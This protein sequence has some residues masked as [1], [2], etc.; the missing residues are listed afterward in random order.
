MRTAPKLRIVFDFTGLK[1]KTRVLLL[2]F[3]PFVLQFAQATFHPTSWRITPFLKV[4]FAIAGL[5]RE[6]PPE[7][8]ALLNER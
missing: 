2:N 5:Y 1:I 3:S 4:V 7:G 6:A 8:C